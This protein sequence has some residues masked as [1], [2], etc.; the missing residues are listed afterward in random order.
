MSDFS[1]NVISVWWK[2]NFSPWGNYIDQHGSSL[3][4]PPHSSGHHTGTPDSS[5]LSFLQLEPLASVVAVHLIFC[6]M[7]YSPN[8]Q[9]NTKDHVTNPGLLTPPLDQILTFCSVCASSFLQTKTLQIQLFE[10]PSVS[11]LSL[12]LLLSRGDTILI[13]VFIIVMHVFTPLPHVCVHKQHILL[14][15]KFLNFV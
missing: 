2:P 14:L 7:V 4:S 5:A 6:Y 9:T 1:L 3:P 10:A 13:S 12:I 11:L 15:S 8:I